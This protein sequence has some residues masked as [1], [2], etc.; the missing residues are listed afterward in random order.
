MSAKLPIIATNVG[1]IPEIIDDEENGFLVKPKNTKEI[2]EKLKYLTKNEEE[3]KKIGEK[4]FQKLIDNFSFEK[5]IL[6]TDKIYQ[7]LFDI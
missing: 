4:A 7:Y 5:M 2:E 6:K 3:R 1:G